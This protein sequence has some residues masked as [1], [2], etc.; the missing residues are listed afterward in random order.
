MENFSMPLAK[1][2]L[3]VALV[4]GQACGGNQSN[5]SQ[6]AI[7]FWGSGEVYARRQPVNCYQST[8]RGPPSATAART[9]GGWA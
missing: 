1:S 3:R 6:E 7:A 9:S 4:L 5:H 2:G 8:F